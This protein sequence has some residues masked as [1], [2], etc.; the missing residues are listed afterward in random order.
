MVVLLASSH[1]YEYYHGTYN[2]DTIFV[3]VW[4]KGRSIHH[5]PCLARRGL[6]TTEAAAAIAAVATAGL[7]TRGSE[8][9]SVLFIF[10]SVP[11]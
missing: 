6:R 11:F 8:C 3:F 7:E 2:S 5:H 1:T 9:T 10:D 4:A